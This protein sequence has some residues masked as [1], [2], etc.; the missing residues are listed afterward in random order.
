M[1]YI[2]YKK[3]ASEYLLTYNW[4]AALLFFKK[5]SQ[6]RGVNPYRE[7]FVK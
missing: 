2:Q 7:I 1:Y 5:I 6:K 3:N 4:G